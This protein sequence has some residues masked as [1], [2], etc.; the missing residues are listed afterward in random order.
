LALTDNVPLITAIGNDDGYENIFVNQLRVHYREGDK[1]IV[2]S[3]SGNSPN[4]VRAAEWVKQKGGRV[5]GLIGFDGGKLKEICDIII[6]V[7]TP[8]GE[9]GPVE[10]I[11]TILDH[12]VANWL[13]YRLKKAFQNRLHK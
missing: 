11:H 12:L 8:K 9:Y 1:L 5:I 13:Q 6:H 4:V 10:D 3:A 2:I 7:E